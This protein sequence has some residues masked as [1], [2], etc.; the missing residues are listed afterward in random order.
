VKSSPWLALAALFAAPVGAIGYGLLLPVHIGRGPDFFQTARI[1]KIQRKRSS[2]WF[3]I[4]CSWLQAPPP[5][6]GALNNATLAKLGLN[7]TEFRQIRGIYAGLERE[8]GA[9]TALANCVQIVRSLRA[10]AR[11]RS[12]DA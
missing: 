1:L 10:S 4:R 3:L 11:A 2:Y 9:F 5:L 7:P 8:L 12:G 6:E